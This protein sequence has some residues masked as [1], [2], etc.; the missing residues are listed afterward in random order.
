MR[1]GRILYAG[2][3]AW[4]GGSGRMEEQP[5]STGE[6]AGGRV[7]TPRRRRRRRIRRVIGILL[8]VLIAGVIAAR[9][10][11]PSYL[12]G[13]VNR[14]ID[15][16]RDYDGSVGAVEI[17]LWRGAYAIADVKIVKTTRA[18]PVPFFEGERVDFTLDWDALLRGE[19]RTRI[20]MQKPK[21]NFVQGRSDDDS[22]SGASGPWLGILEELAPFRVD[23]AELHEGEVHF[24]TFHTNPQ[25]N[26]YLKSLE[27]RLENLTNVSDSLDPLLASASLRG[28]A[29]RGAPFELDMKFDPQSYRPDFSVA[30][31][32]LGVDVTTLNDLA[33]AYGG[34]DF[35]QGELDFV[36]EARASHGFLEGNAKPL[37]R[38]ARI[39]GPGDFEK[40]GPLGVAWQSVVELGGALLK[41]QP[42]DQ[43]GTSVD[44]VGEL[45]DPKTDILEIIGNVLRNAFIEAYLPRFDGRIAPEVI[46]G[47]DEEEALT[48]R[49][50]DEGPRRENA[51]TNASRGSD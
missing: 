20:V 50:Q 4:R 32:L 44:V 39:V 5:T 34:F 41:N 46:V 13:Y 2:G 31:R 48:R 49:A 30:L 16:S 28:T 37:L 17:N 3:G 15:Q 9:L 42:R 40:Y 19:A 7:T 35:E 43:F 45:D 6:T 38:N 22:Q 36:L 14:V 24:R 29:M 21:L 1:P 51:D 18:I 23:S 8:A 47:L 11:L 10:A 25:I 33:R 12:R 26:I 27:G